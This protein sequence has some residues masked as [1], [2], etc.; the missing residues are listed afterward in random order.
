MYWIFRL[1]LLPNLPFLIREASSIRQNGIKL[2][3][4]AQKLSIGDGKSTIL[5][6]GESTAAGVGAS[7]PPKP[8]GRV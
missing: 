1:K 5:I 6:L 7:G 2:P 4:L 8:C 3:S